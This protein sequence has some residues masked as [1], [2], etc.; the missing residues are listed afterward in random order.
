MTD[1][2]GWRKFMSLFYVVL[3]LNYELNIVLANNK[4][5]WV[6]TRHKNDSLR[7]VLFES[8]SF[9]QLSTQQKI[10]AIMNHWELIKEVVSRLTPEEIVELKHETNDLSDINQLGAM[11]PNSPEDKFC[12]CMASQLLWGMT[13]VLPYFKNSCGGKC[14]KFGGPRAIIPLYYSRAGVPKEWR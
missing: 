11:T 9:L 2:S 5:F 1:L 3:L 12:K 13:H 14:Y 7:S 8:Q 4:K 10:D 6:T